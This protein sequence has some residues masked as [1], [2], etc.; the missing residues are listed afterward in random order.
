MPAALRA[1]VDEMAE[2]KVEM[3]LVLETN[4]VY[5]APADLSFAAALR[6]GAARPSTWASIGMRPGPPA[7]GTF[8][9][10]TSWKPGAMSAGYDGTVT[11]QQPLIEPLHGGHSA[12][13]LLA[14][15]VEQR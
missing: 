10:P 3:L 2:G 15:I 1:L 14:A 7:S 12:I 4:P 8:P 6:S 11:I 13:E 9:R 5:T